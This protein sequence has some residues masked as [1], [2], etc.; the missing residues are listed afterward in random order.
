[1]DSIDPQTAAFSKIN[2]E[3]AERHLLLC[4]GPTCCT[5]D[6]GQKTWEFLKARL[7]ELNLPAL[8]TKAACLRVCCGGPWLVVYPEGTWY[9]EVTPDRCERII[10]EHLVGGRPV[11][12]WVVREHR[13]DE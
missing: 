12:D 3:Q 4:I 1:M 5:Y 10:Q 8:R 9:N 13:L 7:K 6:E 2:L 11:S